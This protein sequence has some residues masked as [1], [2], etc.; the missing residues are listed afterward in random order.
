MSPLRGKVLE[1]HFQ[2]FKPPQS[3]KF[4]SPYE[5]FYKRTAVEDLLENTSN[6]YFGQQNQETARLELLKREA[7][8]LPQ[9][10]DPSDD[11]LDLVDV[12]TEV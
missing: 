4:L 3:S 11:R 12:P 8:G 1:D 9:E 7:E 5:E 2:R 6:L 10:D